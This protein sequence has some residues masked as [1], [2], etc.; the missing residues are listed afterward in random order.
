MEL[1]TVSDVKQRH[2]E[3]CDSLFS[4]SAVVTMTLPTMGEFDRP[5]T[6]TVSIPPGPN[7]KA[8]RP[9]TAAPSA[10][11]SQAKTETRPKSAMFASAV[12]KDGKDIL[13]C[14]RACRG[15]AAA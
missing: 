9:K 5:V 12:N 10:N 8:K 1:A 7:A 11:A 14:G 2:L 15:G 6:V 4:S 13:E 3:E